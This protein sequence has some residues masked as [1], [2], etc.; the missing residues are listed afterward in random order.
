MRIETLGF[1]LLAT[2]ILTGCNEKSVAYGD[3]NSIIAVM[4]PELWGEA[5]EDVYAALEQTVQTVRNEKTFTVT[6]QDPGSPEWGNLR[7]FRQMLVVGT[8]SDPWVAEALAASRNTVHEPGMTQVYDVWSRGQN[9]T[10]L[11]LSRPG[12]I[13]ELLQR[14]PE[15]HARLDEQ[16]R[17]Y[18]QSRMF[19]TGADTAL[20]DTLMAEGGFS[21]MVPTVY[22]WSRNDSVF[23]FRNDNPDPSELIR[24]VGVTWQT[25]IPPEMDP[26]G[27]L[28]LRADLVGAYYSQPQAVDLANQSDR[29]I[30][31]REVEALEVRAM[32]TNPPELPW[33]AGGPF[34]TRAVACPDQNRLYLLDAWLYA[35][36]KE[37]YEYMIQ[38]ETIL[39]S[40]RCGPR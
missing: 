9:V 31:L 20:A 12:A 4:T 21:L 33:P 35:P 17:Q 5:S 24:Q 23:V 7:R 36:A 1:L 2:M 38:L 15:Y 10:I 25:P 11:L 32:W 3:A 28:E 40:F 34:V 14:L 18:A 16:F 39:D 8:E 19:M 37:K 13:E 29:R 27:L 30:L 26:E 6:Y 22:K